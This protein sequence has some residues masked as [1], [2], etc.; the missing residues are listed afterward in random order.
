MHVLFLLHSWTQSPTLF[1]KKAKALFLMASASGVK[2][3]TLLSQ[4]DLQLGI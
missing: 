2:A 1:S 4:A 3:I